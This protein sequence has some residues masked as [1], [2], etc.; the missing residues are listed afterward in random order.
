M[1]TRILLILLAGF[2][3]FAAVSCSDSSQEQP[4]TLD[5]TTVAITENT[6]SLTLPAPR[7]VSEKG[8]L[9]ILFTE[10]DS[11]VDIMPIPLEF[12]SQHD[13]ETYFSG[14]KNIEDYIT[15][16]KM[17]KDNYGVSP[18]YFNYLPFSTL[19][20]DPHATLNNFT[21]VRTYITHPELT[22]YYQDFAIVTD[23][24]YHFIG[25]TAWD[26]FEAYIAAKQSTTEN[27][28][29]FSE[30]NHAL[31]Q[32]GNGYVIRSMDGYEVVYQYVNHQLRTFTLIVD[33]WK[34]KI[35]LYSSGAEKVFSSE[36][37]DPATAAIAPLFS[38]NEEEFKQALT[39][40]ILGIRADTDQYDL[41]ECLQK[42]ANIPA[43]PPNHPCDPTIPT[44]QDQTTE[45]QT[46]AAQTAETTP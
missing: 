23:R 29:D 20:I 26:Y 46:T 1:K 11:D 30:L 7:T 3:C 37:S 8:D 28:Y 44:D 5:E 12:Y 25:N 42:V 38:E 41:E 33:F 14:S 32:D 45:S 35:S 21:R 34:I 36:V 22:Y 24:N 43:M 13:L 4:G 18:N 40:M 31:E 9:S 16:P 27:I 19:F 17:I 6:T 10:E 39:K 15:P 2:I